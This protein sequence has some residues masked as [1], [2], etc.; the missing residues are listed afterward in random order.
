LFHAILIFVLLWNR[1]LVESVF[2]EGDLG[3]GGGGNGGPE[4][5]LISLAGPPEP[6][7]PVLETPP[8]EPDPV[9]TVTPTPVPPPPR[10]TAKTQPA[11]TPEPA[12]ALGT[13]VNSGDGAGAGSAGSGGGAGGGSGGGVG[14]GTGVGTGSGSGGGGGGGD[15]PDGLIPPSPAALQMQPTPPKGLHAT[16][17]VL[18]AINATGRVTEVQFKKAS[19]NSKYDSQL[20][21]S[22]LEWRFKPAKNR[23]GQAV[24]SVFEV[25]F[26]I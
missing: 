18:L 23:A 22:A 8:V 1:P 17:T 19:G 21:K 26:T 14:T 13:A 25:T 5:T 11:P 6:P 9:P 12:K 3:G 15:S 7:A 24:D 4:S 16:I 20:K 2:L 10:D